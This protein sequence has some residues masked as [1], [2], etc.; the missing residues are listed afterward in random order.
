MRRGTALPRTRLPQIPELVAGELDHEHVEAGRVAD[1]VEHRNA[2]VAARSR[3]QSTRD[4]QRG[5][6]LSRRRLAVG[7]GD[8][9]P[10]RRRAVGPDDLCPARARRV[11]RRPDRDA[12]FLRPADERMSGREPRRGDDHLGGE[13]DEDAGNLSERTQL[14]PGADDRKQTLV[15]LF[16]GLAQHE[17]RRRRARPT[18]PPPRSPSSRDRARRRA[19][20]ASRRSSS[21]ALP[22]G[23]STRV[24]HST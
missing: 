7:A 22:D 1:G 6:Q 11:R 19:E 5:R 16:G 13:V 20:R 12:G 2:D 4:E 21:S 10:V 23:Q 17:P 8:E 3:S 18:C 9:H 14:E 24:S 15:L